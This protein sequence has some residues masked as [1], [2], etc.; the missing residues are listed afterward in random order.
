MVSGF[1]C[2][3]INETP[4]HDQICL[5]YGIVSFNSIN[6]TSSGS[7]YNSGVDHRDVT[8]SIMKFIIT[9]DCIAGN[10]F[11]LYITPSNQIVEFITFINNTVSKGLIY[12]H[13]SYFILNNSTFYQNIG[14]I[15]FLHVGSF[16]SQFKNCFFDQIPNWGNGFTSQ[17]NCIFNLNDHTFI[18]YSMYFTAYCG[19][20]FKNIDNSCKVL[21]SFYKS[22]LIFYFY[23]IIN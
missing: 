14:P 13:D 23:L 11:G 22:S 1:K 20:Y 2:P 17:T 9:K 21:N 10:V 18:S 4:M 6:I 19:D 12:M 3:E 7:Q 5:R 8:S 15:T 16:L